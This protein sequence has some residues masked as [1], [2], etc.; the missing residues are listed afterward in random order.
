MI[1]L[2]DIGVPILIAIV[3]AVGYLYYLKQKHYYHIKT[4]QELRKLH[5]EAVL[6]EMTLKEDGIITISSGT[7]LYPT[8]G[9][10]QLFEFELK[11]ANKILVDVKETFTP[12][13]DKKSLKHEFTSPG[14][15]NHWRNLQLTESKKKNA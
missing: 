1:M 4:I 2:I 13:Y 8:N 6:E 14:Q 3:S 9:R 15:T 10:I 12:P 5:P 7:A 11:W